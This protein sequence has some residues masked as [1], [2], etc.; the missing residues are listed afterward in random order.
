MLKE[1]REEPKRQR[2]ASLRVNKLPDIN[3]RNSD[4]HPFMKIS[5]ITGG[6]T[7]LRLSKAKR[8]VA[9]REDLQQK[10]KKR[11][12]SRLEAAAREYNTIA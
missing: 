1:G 5:E 8:T 7:R 9:V 12:N 2:D 10:A 11:Q 3:L 6:R 4:G